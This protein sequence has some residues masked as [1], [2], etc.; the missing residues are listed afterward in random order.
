[1]EILLAA[2]VRRRSPWRW[3]CW[4]AGHAR[5]GRGGGDRDGRH[6]HRRVTASRGRQPGATASRRS[7][8]PGGP[9]SRGSRSG[10]AR[11]EASLELQ[12]HELDERERSLEDRRRNL[13]HTREELK[14]REAAAARA[15]ARVGP[16]RG[17]GAS[18]SC[19]DELEDELRHDSARLIRQVEE[20]TR[21]DADRRARS[22][23]AT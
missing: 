16:E 1:M 12:A 23:L 15:G 22:I 10:C 19:C 3:C 21:H 6:D 11:K 17:A 8:A 7:C 18:R 5:R 20:E 2:L 4:C 13:D 14:Q 9:R